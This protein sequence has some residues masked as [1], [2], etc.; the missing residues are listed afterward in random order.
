MQNLLRESNLLSEIRLL[1]E[2]A[3]GNW[4]SEELVGALNRLSI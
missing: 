3:D 1:T 2:T 4:S